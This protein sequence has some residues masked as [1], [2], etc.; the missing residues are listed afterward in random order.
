MD[1]ELEKK[2]T[3]LRANILEKGYDA[4]EFM[5][6][7]QAK[8][9]ELGLD[10]NNWN[11]NE[12][13]SAVY[14]FVTSLGKN[15]I[16]IPKPIEV[17]EDEN[18]NE[19]EGTVNINEKD[20]DKEN[21]NINNNEGENKDIEEKFDLK[22]IEEIIE[23]KKVKPNELSLSK[24]ADIKL[25]FPQKMDGGLFSK[26]YVT[27]LM[28][29]TPFDF[30][31]RK[32]YSDFE[33][34]RNILSIIYV[35]CVIPPLCKKNYADRFSEVLIAKRTRS[36]EKF[37]KGIL[38]HPLLRNDEVFYN[39]IS[40]ENESE[41][42]KKKKMYN[43][44]TSP[45]S[46]SKVKSLTGEI[47]VTVSNDKEIYF[48]NIKNIADLN[49]SIFQKITKGYKSLMTQ[50]DQIS[51]KMKEI[52]QYWKE[53]YNSNI[54]FYEKP[55]TI[56]SYN[57]LSKIMQDWSETNKRQKILINEGIRE[58]FRYIKNEFVSMKDL[59]LKVDTNK[60]VY[61]KAYDKLLSL[62][63]STFRQDISYW[64]LGMVDLESKNE[65]LTN[66]NLAFEKMLPRDTKKVDE[67]R[68]NYGFY[69]NSM[70]SEFERIKDLN[71]QRHKSWV[72]TF[73]KKL[74][75][76]F[77]D[78]QINL[79]D[80]CSYYDEIKDEGEKKGEEKEGEENNKEEEKIEEI[81]NKVNNENDN[82]EEKL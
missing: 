5:N 24:D 31:L 14:E 21:D 2:Q 3:F 37:M 80:R 82:N 33:W 42:E 13:N 35:N 17:Q 16:I 32:R 11:I 46:L 7:L 81:E 53:I 62:K 49:I 61:T 30:K 28:Q 64:G 41:F 79:N 45:T 8:K 40:T 52:S 71:D 38:L 74:I 48:Q 57:I 20:K 58:Y 59:A 51:E 22:K 6:F 12:L 76:S 72:T 26:S 73:I 47:N 27:Y 56:E 23:C 63:E 18:K 65:L 69:L 25:S 60:N 66:K 19:N 50:M 34:L 15:T 68:N 9:G 43:K 75:E 55:N 36:I 70:I 67:L 10:L 78:L 39:F 54:Q 44:I 77:T 1:G 29:T 4:E